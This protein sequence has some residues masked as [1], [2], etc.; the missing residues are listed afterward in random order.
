MANLFLEYF[1]YPTLILVKY[2]A[3]HQRGGAAGSSSLRLSGSLT[4]T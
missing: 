2:N 3:A 1:M 4:L